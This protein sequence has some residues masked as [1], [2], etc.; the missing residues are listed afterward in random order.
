MNSGLSLIKASERLAVSHVFNRFCVIRVRRVT[1]GSASTQ[2][3]LLVPH[4]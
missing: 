4:S 1:A 2:E 3:L